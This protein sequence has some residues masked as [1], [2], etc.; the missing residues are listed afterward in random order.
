MN[1]FENPQSKEE[2]YYTAGGKTKTVD[3]K[4][5]L[6][7]YDLQGREVSQLIS[8]NMHAGYHSVVWNANSYASG[9]YFIKMLAIKKLSL[10]K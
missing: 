5:S 6:S 4:V 2:V 9:M 3:S 10:K 7:I 8:G 1:N